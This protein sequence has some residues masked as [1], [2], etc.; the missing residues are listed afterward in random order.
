MIIFENMKTIKELRPQR[1][2]VPS[3]SFRG[4][5]APQFPNDHFT[6]WHGE[7]G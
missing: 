2:K 1:W 5:K 7:L 6:L 4:E 3:K